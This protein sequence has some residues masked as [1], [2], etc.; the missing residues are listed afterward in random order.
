MQ[1][2]SRR[3]RS[4]I[5]SSTTVLGG[6]PCFLCYTL[7]LSTVLTPVRFCVLVCLVGWLAI[8]LVHFPYHHDA[9]SAPR[10]LEKSVAY[11]DSVY[12]APVTGEEDDVYVQIGKLAA[13]ASHVEEKV[14]SFVDQYGLQNKRV[15]DVGAGSGYSRTSCL[16]IQASIFLLFGAAVFS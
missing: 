9:V 8:I 16:T 13:A 10:H 1:T 14:R 7:S 4:P 15:L 6:K 2:P 3:R 11:Y 5:T 12:Q